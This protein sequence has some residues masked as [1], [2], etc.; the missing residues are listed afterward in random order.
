MYSKV[1][2]AARF[3]KADGRAMRLVGTRIE[4]LELWDDAGLS[5]AAAERSEAHFRTT[6]QL[7][8]MSPGTSCVSTAPNPALAR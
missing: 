5:R 8:L 1:L 7:L 6:Y 2:A 3:R 4:A